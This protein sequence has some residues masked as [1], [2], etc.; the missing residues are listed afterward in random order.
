MNY[1]FVKLYLRLLREIQHYGQTNCNEVVVLQQSEHSSVNKKDLLVEEVTGTSKK[2][3][4]DKLDKM[5]KRKREVKVLF[6]RKLNFNY[7]PWPRL[8]T[9]LF[10]DG[11]TQNLLWVH[12][13]GMAWM[14]CRS[15][16]LIRAGFC[17]NILLCHLR[18]FLRLSLPCL[19]MY[20]PPLIE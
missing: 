18:L 4:T 16:K 8:K 20:L 9:A 6:K 2:G 7:F 3:V 1:R 17:L 15:Y 14:V 10:C 11:H 13:M 19:C 12:G 5:K